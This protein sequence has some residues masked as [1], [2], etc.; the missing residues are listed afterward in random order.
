MIY[1]LEECLCTA[2]RH[3]TRPT[4]DITF[5]KYSWSSV[6]LDYK[7]KLI[8]SLDDFGQGFFDGRLS[9]LT[10]DFAVSLSTPIFGPNFG[11][12]GERDE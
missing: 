4:T 11:M 3:S 2:V 1:N 6:S 7:K 8:N 12:A 10:C 5:S 9:S